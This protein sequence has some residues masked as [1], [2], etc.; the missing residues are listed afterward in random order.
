MPITTIA[1]YVTG[2]NN[3]LENELN[4]RARTSTYQETVKE[5]LEENGNKL[6]STLSDSDKQYIAEIKENLNKSYR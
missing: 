3:T 4:R 6:L 5:W 1:E 2:L